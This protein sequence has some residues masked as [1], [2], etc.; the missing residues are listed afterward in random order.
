MRV[1]NSKN[2]QYKIRQ[3]TTHNKSG[4]AFGITIPANVAKNFMNCFFTI[5]VKGSDIILHSGCNFREEAE[6]ETFKDFTV[7]S[8]KVLSLNGK[9]KNMYA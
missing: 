8:E 6:K 2:L 1:P 3:L 4:D 5:E 7:E 9:K